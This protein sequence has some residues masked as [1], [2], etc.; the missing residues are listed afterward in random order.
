VGG[1][2]L[3]PD[4]DRGRAEGVAEPEAVAMI[5]A[6]VDGFV[7]EVTPSGRDVA[8]DGA[9]LIVAQNVELETERERLLARRRLTE[10]ERD[11]ASLDEFALTQ[12]LD[13]RLAAIDDQIAQVDRRLASLS[14]RAPERGLWIAP[15]VERL[16]GAHVKRG[17]AI[18][19]VAS[20]DRILVRAVADQ[21]LGPRI[22]PEIGAGGAVEIRLRGRPDLIVHGR[23]RDVLPAGL[24]RLPSAALGYAAGGLTPVAADDESGM[25]SA[26]PFFEVRI[27]VDE[28][29]GRAGAL[30][31]GQRVVVRFEMPARPLA[32]QWIRSLRQLL[33]RRFEI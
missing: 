14:I 8:P 33:Q 25:T 32:V 1:L 7:S 12:S 28:A 24:Q 20:T 29:T 3:E 23:V 27:D 18:G 15:D 5:Y 31:S 6:Q 4:P 11:R 13:Q 10:L 21:S 2:G 26:E 9:P 16:R 17:D 22:E 30:C 19:L